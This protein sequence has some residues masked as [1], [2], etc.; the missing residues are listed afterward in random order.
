MASSCR[1]NLV[2]QSWPDIPR[3]HRANQVKSAVNFELTRV[4]PA[5]L[6]MKKYVDRS[7]EIDVTSLHFSLC[8]ALLVVACLC[9][10]RG[11]V[12]GADTW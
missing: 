7:L 10:D 9:A 3:K 12:I 8:L 2:A 6:C 5:S 1:F 11:S 4:L